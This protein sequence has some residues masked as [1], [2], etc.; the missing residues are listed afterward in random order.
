MFFL[1]LSAQLNNT[2]Y[3]LIKFL[4]FVKAIRINSGLPKTY[5]LRNNLIIAKAF[6]FA[7]APAHAKIFS[8]DRACN[9]CCSSTGHQVQLK[10]LLRL[11][12]YVALKYPEQPSEYYKN[13]LLCVPFS[14]RIVC[15]CPIC[16]VVNALVGQPQ[17]CRN[18]RYG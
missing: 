9:Y 4:K 3:I 12:K 2:A 1:L 11:N 13:G 8:Y 14:P 10:R 5:Q 7:R 16:M 15:G 18:S 6:D 17:I